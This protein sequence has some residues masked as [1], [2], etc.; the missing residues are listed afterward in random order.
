MSLANVKSLQHVIV[1]DITNHPVLWFTN[2][3]C[4]TNIQ[5]IYDAVAHSLAPFLDA[6]EVVLLGSGIVLDRFKKIDE[7]VWPT[8]SGRKGWR[9]DMWIVVRGF[10]YSCAPMKKAQMQEKNSVADASEDP[11]AASFVSFNS[12]VLQEVKEPQREYPVV[13]PVDFLEFLENQAAQKENLVPS[14]L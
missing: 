7:M 14:D 4:Q 3:A 10:E 6:H 5:L 8:R 9:L 11:S 1:C 2:V 13:D 12:V